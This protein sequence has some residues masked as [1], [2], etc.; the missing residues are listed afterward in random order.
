MKLNADDL[1]NLAATLRKLD[2]LGQFKGEV[3]AVTSL[4][5]VT[6]RYEYDVEQDAHYVAFA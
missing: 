1:K 2:E 3:D 5:G 4:G 6:F